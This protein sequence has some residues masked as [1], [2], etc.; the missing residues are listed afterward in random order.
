MGIKRQDDFR[1]TADLNR[2]RM[3]QAIPQRAN[4]DLLAKHSTMEHFLGKLDGYNS[5]PP[6]NRIKN[7]P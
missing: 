6:H 7:F 5:S 2:A 3:A 4:D 1:A